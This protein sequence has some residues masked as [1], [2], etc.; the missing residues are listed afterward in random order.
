MSISAI[1]LPVFVQVALTFV[2]LIWMGRSRIAML[3][4]GSV[5]V[6]DIALGERNWPRPVL[7]IANAFHN[8]FELPLLFFVLV[9]LAM[10]TRKADLTFVVMSWVFVATRLVHAFVHTTSNKVAW[11]FQIFLIGAVI[12]VLMWIVFALRIFWSQAGI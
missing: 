12:L 1:L 7:Q 6:K 4:S 8:Q 10:I 9:A 5:E 11:R 2:L 3:R